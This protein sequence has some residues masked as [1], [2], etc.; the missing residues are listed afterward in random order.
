MKICLQHTYAEELSDLVVP[1]KPAPVAEPR[2]VFFHYPLA[3]ELGFGE[4][5]VEPAQLAAW[6][7]GCPLP[8]GAKP[9]AQA[10]AGHQF[11]NFSPQLGDGRALLIGEVVDPRGRRFDLALKGSG[12]TPF[13]RGGDG[14]AAVGP[15]LREVLI[16]EGLHAL[17]I[18]TT[19]SLAVVATGQ[20]VYRPRPLPGAILTRVASSHIRVGTFEF[21]AARGDFE[22]VEKLFR[23]TLARHYP[24]LVGH[25]D[26]Y[27]AFLLAVGQR[28][29]DLLAGWMNVGFIHGVMNTDNMA[30]SGETIDFGPCA[31]LESYNPRTVF[32]SIDHQGRYAYANQPTIARWNLAR[33][34]ETLLP[35]L[36]A[37]DNRAVARATELLAEF[38]PAYER[39]WLQGVRRKLGLQHPLDEVADRTL[40]NDWLQLLELHELDFTLS[41]RRLAQGTL[42]VE[43]LDPWLKRW[44][45][46]CLADDQKGQLD[47]VLGAQ[48][49]AA[50]MLKANPWVIPRNHKVEQA[51]E[52]ASE[53]DDLKPFEALL[54]ALR[55]PYDDGPE[56]EA[57]SQP[58]PP[59]VTARYQTFCGT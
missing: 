47:P 54:Q 55:R 23:Y 24:E 38:T 42:E 58:A 44:Q 2:L 5:P 15:M 19:R 43:A 41:W 12:R 18:P 49:R 53:A 56:Q 32:S 28:Q 27:A 26:P 10:Y 13:S 25:E 21:F 31:F 6:F 22:S 11:G 37:D 33:L 34:A 36:D 29:A 39:A 30:I 14:L 46:R 4:A 48:Q 35:F 9:V 51:L 40:A 50:R 16:S 20:P 7:S 59:E 3:L 17:G 8:E 52:A 45:E 57:Y 1:W